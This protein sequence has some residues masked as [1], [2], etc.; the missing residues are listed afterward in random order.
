MDGIDLNLIRNGL[1]EFLLIVVSLSLHEWAHAVVADRLGDDTPR[2]MGRVTLNP[3]PH[4]D[5]IGT[6]IVPIVSIFFFP[7]F[8]LIGWG[9]PVITNANNF[10]HRQLY[11]ILATLAGPAA[12]FLLALA[13]VVAG[14]L[15]VQSD[16]RLA[17]LLSPLILVNVI[18][19]VFNLL[20]IP[21][22]DGGYVLRRLVG[23]S[24]ETFLAIS[25]WSGLVMLL[26]INFSLVRGIF[27]V[28]FLRAYVPYYILCHAL[29][30]AAAALLFPI[31]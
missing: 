5:L 1:I 21:P 7:G 30:P 12:N 31:S 15:F 26:A 24:D 8:A 23:M 2:A 18:L 27:T 13:G 17:E 29:N 19:G 20:P 14:A 25:R 4:I 3:L 11:D 16:P 22:L 28:I 10:K 9:K 6:I